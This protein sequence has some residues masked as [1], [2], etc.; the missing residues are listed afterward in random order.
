MTGFV[1]KLWRISAATF[2]VVVILLA[3]IIGL[4]RLVLTQVPEHREQIQALASEAIGLPVELGGVDARLSWHGP[5]LGF[6]DAP[7]LSAKDRT[8]SIARDRALR[9]GTQAR[10]VK[11][12]VNE[13]RAF[14]AEGDE[15]LVEVVVEATV[16]G[17]PVL[18]LA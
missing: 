6:T 5:E 15:M 8:A 13:R 2:A 3:V 4:F 16:S 11:H 9:A 14:T 17:K 1:R 12:V 10:E 7:I 18:D